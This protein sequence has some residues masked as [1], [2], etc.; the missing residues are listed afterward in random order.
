MPNGA[1]DMSAM[2]ASSNKPTIAKKRIVGSMWGYSLALWD[3]VSLWTLIIGMLCGAV[4]VFLTGIS[5]FISLRTSA[6]AQTYLLIPHFNDDLRGRIQVP[7]R[8][9][10]GL[11]FLP[12][13]PTSTTQCKC[14]L[15]DLNRSVE[16]ATAN[17][18]SGSTNLRDSH[19]SEMQA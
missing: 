14:V 8:T 4:A 5:S 18:A 6:I 11:S 15:I 16:S 13:R 7:Q 17:T 2:S 1:D 19:T 9:P 10:T 12:T 3:K